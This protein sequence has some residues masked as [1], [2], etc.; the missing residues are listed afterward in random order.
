MGLAAHAGG[1]SCRGIIGDPLH[2]CCVALQVDA[3][4]WL[5][6]YATL[7]QEAAE[8]LR[9]VLASLLHAAAQQPRAQPDEVDAT[10]SEAE[11]DET[12]TEAI[13]EELL[14]AAGSEEA[15]AALSMAHVI[16]QS[17][18]G[19]PRCPEL[20][21]A[22]VHMAMKLLEHYPGMQ[23]ELLLLLGA[24]LSSRPGEERTPLQASVMAACIA[25][26]CAGWR[27]RSYRQRGR[28]A[29]ELPA[30]ASR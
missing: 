3:L 12:G 1:I 10:E 13:D 5:T 15:V 2:P 11:D 6:E 28:T 24:L 25:C 9:G 21:V 14:Q 16:E 8:Q 26:A 18:A 20:A 23:D 22:A 7:S 17:M 30:A 19:P 27:L 29:K 4:T